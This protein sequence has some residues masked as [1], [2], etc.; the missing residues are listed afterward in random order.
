MA[1]KIIDEMHAET[2]KTIPETENITS[3]TP[4]GKAAEKKT[5]ETVVYCGPTIKGIVQQYAHFTKGI[6][7]SLKEY[8]ATHKSIKRLIVPLD[9]FIVTK[10]NIQTAGTIEYLTYNKIVKGE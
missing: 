10:K 8:I 6:P 5:P 4:K 1:K 7:K 3:E 9:N 2:Q